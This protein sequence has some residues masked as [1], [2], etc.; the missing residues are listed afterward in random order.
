MIDDPPARRSPPPPDP[1]RDAEAR[2]FH[3]LRERGSIVGR[4]VSADGPSGLSDDEAQMTAAARAAAAL[5]PADAV[6]GLGT[7]TTVSHLLP[8]IAERTDGHVFVATSAS[9]EQLAGRLGIAIERFDRL[10]HLDVAIDGADEITPEG[11]LIKGGGGA[12]VRE[13]V[14]AANAGRFIVI[15]SARKEVARL[16]RAVPVE[17]LAFGAAATLHD[18]RRFGEVVLRSSE[19]SPN[20][21]LIADIRAPL[22]DPRT[23]S[24]QLDRLP[25]VLGHGLFG[26]ELV[27]DIIIGR[28]D[29]VVH[30]TIEHEPL[31]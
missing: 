5:I 2:R 7:G 3:A 13:K 12:H 30:R 14:V 23:L 25:G 26:P 18:L 4:M 22:H 20:G 8:L 24:D 27:D 31:L 11:W 17:L 16:A 21:G 1:R 19:P 29:G 28:E 9:T 10:V 15:G 6:V